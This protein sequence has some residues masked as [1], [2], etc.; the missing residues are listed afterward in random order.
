M[1]RS[2]AASLAE[3][4]QST[5]MQILDWS[6]EYS[7]RVSLNLVISD[8]K[9]LVACRCANQ[10]PAPSLYWLQSNTEFPNSVVVASEPLFA[11]QAWASFPENSVLSVSPDLSTA[12]H[13][14]H[15]T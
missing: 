13:K 3:V 7:V 8:G 6:R 12:I 10:S 11:D 4:L 1:Q 5:I 14:L 15:L 2:P 9:Q